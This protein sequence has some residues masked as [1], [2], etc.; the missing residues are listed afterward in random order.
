MGPRA[1][2]SGAAIRRC[3]RLEAGQTP[4]V[5][6]QP[7]SADVA[8]ASA[9]L[10]TVAGCTRRECLRAEPPVRAH[11]ALLGRR[12]QR[13]RRRACTPSNARRLRAFRRVRI[14]EAASAA[15]AAFA[16][17]SPGAEAPPA[18]MAS[19]HRIAAL[20]GAPPAELGAYRGRHA[21][22]AVHLAVEAAARL[23]RRWRLLVVSLAARARAA[24][25]ASGACCSRQRAGAAPPRCCDAG[26]A[27]VRRRRAAGSTA[28]IACVAGCVPTLRASGPR[29]R[30]A[31]AARR[32]HDPAASQGRIAT[33]WPKRA[34]LPSPPAPGRRLSPAQRAMAGISAQD[35]APAAQVMP[36]VQGDADDTRAAHVA[37]LDTSSGCCFCCTSPLAT[38]LWCLGPVRA[39]DSE[40]ASRLRAACTRSEAVRR[41][42]TPRR[43]ASFRAPPARCCSRERRRWR[44]CTAST[45]VRRAP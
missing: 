2:R 30:R 33:P 39:R 34:A 26:G 21:Q 10:A 40:G 20:R 9:A 18:G 5:R 37:S 13:R 16:A 29:A 8:A 19:R 36:S 15:A 4:L 31:S 17:A 27:A 6:V 7:P 3:C 23:Q 25:S 11:A 42:H 14:G 22:G 38:L 24:R 41:V 44:R 45:L 43:L 12:A 32:R 1:P 28:C 35:T